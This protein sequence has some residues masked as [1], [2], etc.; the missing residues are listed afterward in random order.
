MRSGK[1]RQERQGPPGT[2]R[3]FNAIF[4]SSLIDNTGMT[5]MPVYREYD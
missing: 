2:P 1:A 4:D 5:N 3:I